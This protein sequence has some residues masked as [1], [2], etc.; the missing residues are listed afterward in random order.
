MR[1]VLAAACT[2]LLIGVTCGLL[3]ADDAADRPA[4]RQ[5]ADNEAGYLE[6]LV[7]RH[8]AT[9][10]WMARERAR[11]RD[12]GAV[13]PP[14]L[15]LLVPGPEKMFLGD[16]E[17]VPIPGGL[18]PGLHVFLPGPI[19]FGFGGEDQEPNTITNF[20]GFSAIGYFAG[21]TDG[22]RRLSV[23][24]APPAGHAIVIEGAG[25][26]SARCDAARIDQTENR[27]LTVVIVPP[28]SHAVGTKRTR[29]KR[30]G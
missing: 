1:M 12:S 19:E 4:I 20:K 18:A 8:A 9:H 16:V 7:E 27:R 5:S 25:V 13:V 21:T 14:G 6:R 28:A 15:R 10:A 29:V 24:I 11:L 23:G 17:P 3:F 2:L 30:P 26:I 22:Y